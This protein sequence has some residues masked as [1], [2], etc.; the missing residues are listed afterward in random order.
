MMGWPE[1]VQHTQFRRP[2]TMEN[3]GRSSA[4]PGGRWDQGMADLLLNPAA[5]LSRIH[6]AVA[7][8]A[9]ARQS[10]RGSLR[11]QL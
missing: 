11:A 8:W 5:T 9:G 2:L 10:W 7:L 3:S 6:Y 1:R 4:T